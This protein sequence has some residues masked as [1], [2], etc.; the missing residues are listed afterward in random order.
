MLMEQLEA[1][2][3]KSLKRK[4]KAS[5]AKS[6]LEQVTHDLEVAERERQALLAREASSAHYI[7]QIER[8]L[9]N[10]EYQCNVM[11][12]AVQTCQA[13]ESSHAREVN[14]LTE[15]V[16]QKQRELRQCKEQLQMSKERIS[17][18]EKRKRF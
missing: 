11:N 7:S 4:E 8:Q 15:E 1:S 6:K 18:V 13:R 5:L 17:S 3:T 16:R 12:D 2:D 10:Y 9:A 14:R